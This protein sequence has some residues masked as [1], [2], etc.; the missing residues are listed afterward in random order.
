MF[1]H[2][3]VILGYHPPVL[4]GIGCH[5]LGVRIL[6][7][8]SGYL[9]VMSYK[10]NNSYQFLLKRIVRV[11]PGLIFFTLG[12]AFILGPFFTRCTITEY[13]TYF[14][15][16]IWHNILLYPIF[17]LPG[18]FEN[19]PYPITV[20]GSLW[21]L[22]IEVFGYLLIPICAVCV[23]QQTYPKRK[24]IL[25]ILGVGT[26]VLCYIIYALKATNIISARCI[27]WGT[28]WINA[29]EVL[30]YFALGGA[31][32]CLKKKYLNIQYSIVLVIAYMLTSDYAN[33]LIR[34]FVITYLVLSVAY[35]SPPQLGKH[36]EK[37]DC[38]YTF[39]LWQMPIQQSVINILLKLG[40]SSAL[41][42]PVLL[43]LICFVIVLSFSWFVTKFFEKSASN[44][45]LKKLIRK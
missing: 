19:N 6:F 14:K 23:K 18:V 28:D 42:H 41:S 8:V 44:F 12:S 4:L 22:P 13:F 43:F 11:M 5:T 3:Y 35:A 16:Y 29:F 15:S 39:Y 24:T 1:G 9:A 38:N 17:D 25:N 40:C 36:F 7:A 26:V 45:F 10:R 33:I 37:L 30:I 32:A 20:N 34:P 27:V 31:A 2:Q 21:T